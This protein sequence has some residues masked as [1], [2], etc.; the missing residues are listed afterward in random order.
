MIGDMNPL[1][2]TDHTPDQVQQFV[3]FLPL[4]RYDEPSSRIRTWRG[5]GR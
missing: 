5:P 2:S 3:L 4:I 1:T